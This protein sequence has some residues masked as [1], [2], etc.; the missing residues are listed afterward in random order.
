MSEIIDE[1]NAGM[2]APSIFNSVSSAYDVSSAKAGISYKSR[3][4]L[5]PFSQRQEDTLKKHELQNLF[6]KSMQGAK[7]G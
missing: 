7:R 1:S 5:L 2:L 3:R 4:K 6:C